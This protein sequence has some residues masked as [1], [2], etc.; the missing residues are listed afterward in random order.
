MIPLVGYLNPFLELCFSLLEP[1]T[2]CPELFP[3][4]STV[5]MSLMR[6]PTT[7]L[8]HGCMRPCSGCALQPVPHGCCCNCPAICGWLQLWLQHYGPPP[9]PLQ[10][11]TLL[12]Q[13]LP[14]SSLCSSLRSLYISCPRSC[15]VALQS[16]RPIRTLKN[17][18]FFILIFSQ[19]QHS[20]LFHSKYLD[21]INL[22]LQIY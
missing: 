14:R 3:V 13:L 4:P 7:S 9:S 1:T 15:M 8:Y 19:T 10:P 5:C 22:L 21:V 20:V 2:H 17:S 6:L 12:R 18:P 11:A 16:V